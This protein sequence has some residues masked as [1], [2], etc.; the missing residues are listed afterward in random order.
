MEWKDL[1]AELHR[2]LVPSQATSRWDD[3]LASLADRSAET[4]P[5]RCAA[6][7]ELHRSF[8]RDGA[9]RWSTALML[10]Y[11]PMLSTLRR[12]I[13]G[14]ADRDQLVLTAFLEALADSARDP[15]CRAL[16]WRTRRRLFRR[17]REETAPRFEPFVDTAADARFAEH[18]FVQ[19]GLLRAIEKKHGLVVL[20]ALGGEPLER[21][22]ACA[23]PDATVPERRSLRM[24]L[25]QRRARARA[26]LRD[27]FTDL[28]A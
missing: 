23:Y 5:S 17:V 10:A 6:L 9:R 7:N 27:D 1:R 8:H 12:R 4:R 11:W 20:A 16:A 21:L 2:Q 3:V 13:A 18:P 28:C 14:I 15:D 25:K 19:R 22:I 24:A 26:R